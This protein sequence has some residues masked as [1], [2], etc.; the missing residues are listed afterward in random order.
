MITFVIFTYNE[1]ERIER[2][3]QN[4]QKFGK[5]LLADNNSTDRTHEIAQKY[6][7][8]IF[9]RKED[10]V[11]VE[12]QKLVDQLYEVIDTE[13]LYWGFA[14]EML[15]Y[16]TLLE[17]SRV[18]KLDNCDIISMD[19]KN[20]FYGNFCYD[21]YHA[22]TFKIFKKGAIDFIG[23]KIHNMGKATVAEDRILNLADKYFIHH[24]ISNTS[25]S[26]LNVINRYTESEDRTNSK[27]NTSFIY[28]I[29]LSIKIVVIDLF[30]SKFY[31]SGYSS[32]ALTQLMIFYTL[33]K[34]MKFF[35]REKN[36]NNQTI[37]ERNNIYRDRIIK[38]FTNDDK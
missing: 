23:N 32:L 20:Y 10:Y 2:V 30:R 21:L 31:R 25:S 4:F 18:I 37:E 27:L 28:F 36:L 29:L 11:F 1:A 15:E 38:S 7:C 26:Y 35:E 33:I 19:R 5:I 16:E 13:W 3:I 9:L 14:D 22:R 24:F 17:I 8:K 12:N 34:N 6:G